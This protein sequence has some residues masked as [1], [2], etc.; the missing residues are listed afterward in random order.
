MILTVD[1]SP[2][3]EARLK[4]AAWQKRLDPS[5]LAN[6]LPADHLPVEDPP[7]ALSA[8]W[9]EEDKAMTPEEREQEQRLWGQFE[10]SVNGTREASGMR[11]LFID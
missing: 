7:L 1:L 8:Q 11:R 10:I 5:T 6:R 4:T 3:E 2:A 9:A